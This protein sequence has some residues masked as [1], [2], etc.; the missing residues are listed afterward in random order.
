M[1]PGYSS[2]KVS[3]YKPA[4][5]DAML[6]GDFHKNTDSGAT[7]SVST[8][9]SDDKNGDGD[10]QVVDVGNS[11]YS[12]LWTQKTKVMYVNTNIKGGGLRCNQGSF[13]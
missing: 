13:P 2:T 12:S 11:C 1:P 6:P 5:I 3:A 7:L 9:T 4:S 10:G 8:I